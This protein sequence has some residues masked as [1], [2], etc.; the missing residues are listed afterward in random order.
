M[1]Q[2]VFPLT[3]PPRRLCCNRGLVEETVGF[4]SLRMRSFRNDESMLVETGVILRIWD[5]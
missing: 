2:G 5:Y 3:L 4:Q 1:N